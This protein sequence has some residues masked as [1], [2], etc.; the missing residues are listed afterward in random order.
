MRI[1][2]ET[3]KFIENHSLLFFLYPI[4][5][6]DTAIK[7]MDEMREGRSYSNRS[8][9]LSVVVPRSSIPMSVAMC[10]VVV[11]M[12]CSWYGL[13]FP[14]PNRT[15]FPI[16]ASCLAQNHPIDPIHCHHHHH[17]CDS[18]WPNHKYLPLQ[19]S[20][21]RYPMLVTTYSH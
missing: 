13:L 8:R 14:P 10:Y 18:W 21:V 15:C 16:D 12:L 4:K 17:H 1:N 6:R 3:H 19:D 2:T 9:L 7:P 11:W 5:H 20:M